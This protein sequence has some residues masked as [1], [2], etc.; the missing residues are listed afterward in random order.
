MVMERLLHLASAALP[1]GFR[2][3]L[4]K[5]FRY[6]VGYEQ[7]LGEQEQLIRRLARYSH[8]VG[9]AQSYK[10]ERLTDD[11][12]CIADAIEKRL[13]SIEARLGLEGRERPLPS[14]IRPFTRFD[15]VEHNTPMIPDTEYRTLVEPGFGGYWGGLYNPGLAVRNGRII[16]AARAEDHDEHERNADLT[17]MANSVRPLIIECDQD[18]KILDSYPLTLKNYPFDDGLFR[19]EDYRI[20]EMDGEMYVNH[21]LVLLPRDL[22]G[23]RGSFGVLQTLSRIDLTARTMEF[24]GFP[25]TDR[26][27]SPVEKN[28]VYLK[29]AAGL[30]L[31]YLFSPGYVVK[32]LVSRETLEF[33]TIIDQNIPVPGCEFEYV[34]YS[35]NPVPYDDRHQLLFVHVRRETENKHY[36]QWA[37]LI[38]N[39]SLMPVKIS[40]VPILKGG[41]ARGVF[42]RCIYI[43]GVLRQGARWL[44]VFGE[45]DSYISYVHVGHDALERSFISL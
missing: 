11:V 9:R 19:L 30:F 4:K 31:F 38:D 12:V 13:A 18:M 39:V 42:P 44:L 6:L 22:K 40:R 23:Y 43:T 2:N 8:Q 24:V 33:K 17:K 20:F 35:T 26:M 28:W 25:R 14:M 3:R 1:K 45:G 37:V 34:S 32:K 21:G 5:A 15:A 7:E 36:Y 27:V 10:D 29:N 16:L 41:T